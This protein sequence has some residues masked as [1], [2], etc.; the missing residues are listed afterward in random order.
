MRKILSAVREA[1][2]DVYYINNAGFILAPV[3]FAAHLHGKKVLFWGASDTNFDPSYKW[4]RMPTYRDKVLYLWGMKRCDAYVVQ[5]RFQQ[6]MLLR[7]FGKPSRIISNGLFPV[8][9]LSSFDGFVLWVGSMRKVKNPMMFVELARRLPE[10]RFVMV[11]GNPLQ[12]DEF[13]D[14]VLEAGK[15][16][17]NL[18]FRGFM[19]F[20]EVEQMFARASLFV[21]TSTIEGFPNTFLQ[22][23]SR[24]V[25][26]VST[27]N[28]NPDEL[29]TRHKLGAVAQD[30]DEMVR[31][32]KKYANGGLDVS[33]AGIKAFFDSNLTIER[34][35]DHMEEVL[36]RMDG[37]S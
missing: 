37:A 4:F 1:D 8:D 10:A 2:A 34:T 23:W 7:H 18:D 11:G 30:L 6:E 26:V 32:V 22:A 13:Y 25:P 31:I 36:Q 3:V 17:P 20:A 29:I 16:I 21:N 14:A 5:N 9:R 15:S 12:R 35:V 27:T 28:V 33:P 19:P 24:G